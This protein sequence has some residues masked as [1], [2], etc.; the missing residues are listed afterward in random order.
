MRAQSFRADVLDC[1]VV[2]S[3]QTVAAAALTA[4]ALGSSCGEE[5]CGLFDEL[6]RKL[7]VRA[8]PGIRVEDQPASFY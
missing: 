5:A 2:R 4:A 6:F 8:V 1:V 3:C 7:E